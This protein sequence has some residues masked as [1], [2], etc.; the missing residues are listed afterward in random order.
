MFV[1]CPYG[2]CEKW[3]WQL[4]MS[5]A[6]SRRC[7]LSSSIRWLGTAEGRRRSQVHDH[8]AFTPGSDMVSFLS[9]ALQISAKIDLPVRQNG[10]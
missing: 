1:V 5:Y 4:P 2:A 10:L 3:N 9:E 8:A 7:S 6:V